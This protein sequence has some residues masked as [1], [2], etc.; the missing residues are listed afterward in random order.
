MDLLAT[1]LKKND[2]FIDT[3]Y[4]LFFP[5]IRSITSD[6]FNQ[7]QCKDVAKIIG[8]PFDVLALRRKNNESCL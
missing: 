3:T 6:A 4:S 8:L 2:N 5:Y 1:P 7:K